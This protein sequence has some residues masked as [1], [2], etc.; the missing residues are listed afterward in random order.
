MASCR[1]IP[2]SDYLK[3]LQAM[4]TNILAKTLLQQARKVTS[5]RNLSEFAFVV[6]FTFVYSKRIQSNYS[7]SFTSSNLY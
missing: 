6:V 7:A 1:R 3:E 5:K 4:L 2:K